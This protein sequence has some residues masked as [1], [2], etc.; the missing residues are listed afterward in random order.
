MANGK[1]RHHGMKEYRGIDKEIDGRGIGIEI[2]WLFTT[3]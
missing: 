1:G 2:G 3:R